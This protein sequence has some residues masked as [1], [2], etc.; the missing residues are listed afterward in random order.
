MTWQLQIWFETHGLQITENTLYY[1]DLDKRRKELIESKLNLPPDNLIVVCSFFNEDNFL[2]V[3]DKYLTW[4]SDND[5]GCIP[6]RD[7]LRFHRQ[8]DFSDDRYE[9]RLRCYH[10]GK[11]KNIEDV[12]PQSTIPN[13]FLCDGSPLVFIKASGDRYY[14]FK[15]EPGRHIDTIYV[16]IEN[17]KKHLR[18]ED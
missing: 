2:L 11:I 4:H 6:L 17:A 8:G 16:G 7:V 1:R 13:Y 18:A 14:D 15:V 9:K 10:D 12:D 3:G 5:F